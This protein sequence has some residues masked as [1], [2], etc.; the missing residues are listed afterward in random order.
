MFSRI[1]EMNMKYGARNLDGNNGTLIRS[2]CKSGNIF[3]VRDLIDKGVNIHILSD[4]SILLAANNGH[5]EVIKILMPYVPN[6]EYALRGA[7]LRG[8]EG[9]A[10]MLVE[11]DKNRGIK[12]CI[13]K[14]TFLW[15]C[16]SGKL[17]LVK[18]LCG[19]LED[20]NEKIAHG[21]IDECIFWTQKRNNIDILEFLEEIKTE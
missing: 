12:T 14:D 4:D 21:D 1:T 8:H 16:L 5:E 19:I 9:V 10:R 13:N 18:F 11:Y 17:S 20:R 6:L 3:V 2:A 7:C 15:A